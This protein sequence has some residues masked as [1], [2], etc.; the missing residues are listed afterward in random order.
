M[1]LPT[2]DPATRAPFAWL[3]TETPR[4]LDE[5]PAVD[6]GPPPGPRP[7]FSVCLPTY[8]RA[9]MLGHAIR[10]VLTQTVEDFELIVCDNASTDE[11]PEVVRSFQD[12]RLRYLRYDRL[13][14]MYANH[15]RC[16]DGVRADWA[17]YLHSDDE[18]LPDCLAAIRDVVA[19][20]PEPPAVIGQFTPHEVYDRLLPDL[21]APLIRLP[22]D[23]G[24]SVH[25]A[26]SLFLPPS[27]T[28]YRTEVLR[29]MPFDELGISGDYLLSMQLLFNGHVIVLT[30]RALCRKSV[31]A[32]SASAGSLWTGSFHFS[33]ARI[34]RILTDHPAW[35][36][37]Q[38]DLR[39]QIRRYP[40]YFQTHL[41][42][43][44]AQAGRWRYFWELLPRVSPLALL[45]RQW[46]HILGAALLGRFYWRLIPHLTSPGT[47][48]R[49]LLARLRGAA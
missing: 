47:R 1:A 28:A 15:N 32:A 41:L 8:N 35:A 10:S 5:R 12:P 43:A 30:R 18:L 25:V 40:L 27:G 46:G 36:E 38:R 45:T 13:V 29:K 4:R 16:L 39:S 33:F 14:G 44:F 21:P 24:L 3:A 37:V 19:G 9:K 6:T 22:R 31:H 42:K 11:T 49:Y 48:V 7:A 17:V 2:P 20:E 26:H 34:F 23:T